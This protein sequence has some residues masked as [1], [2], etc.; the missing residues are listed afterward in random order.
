[1]TDL[2][3]IEAALRALETDV[4]TA[5]ETGQAQAGGHQ[6]IHFDEETLARFWER[7]DGLQT[8]LYASGTG[9]RELRLVTEEHDALRIR[10]IYLRHL[11][12]REVPRLYV[13][14]ALVET[15]TRPAPG[16]LPA[17]RQPAAAPT[18][19]KE[20][21]LGALGSAFRKEESTKP[22]SPARR[23]APTAGTMLQP[24]MR[25]IYLHKLMEEDAMKLMP[26]KARPPRVADNV[27]VPGFIANFS[28][29]DFAETHFAVR[30]PTAKQAIARTPEELR[31]KLAKRDEG[32]S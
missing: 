25:L 15:R 22:T 32:K 5:Y 7:L 10:T 29:K 9:P 20:G 11:L 28:A 13:E 27:R 6:T 16:Q 21:I 17:S 8:S 18:A 26:E 24:Q 31:A 30:S 1:M 12:E 19:R 2:L 3:P 14:K 4:I 23:A